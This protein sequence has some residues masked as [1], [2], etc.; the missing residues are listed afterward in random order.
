MFVESLEIQIMVEE[1]ENGY[2][3]LAYFYDNET[4]FHVPLKLSYLST[5]LI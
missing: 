5:T 3:K 4:I 2:E 1:S